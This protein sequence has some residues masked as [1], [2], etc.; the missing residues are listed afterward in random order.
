MIIE[1]R[2]FITAEVTRE[3]LLPP[4]LFGEAACVEL[5]T[6][7]GVTYVFVPDEV[8][9]PVEQPTEIAD[10]IQP[11]T[12]TADLR[13]VIEDASP[14]VALIRERVAAKIA[15]A[16]SIGDEIKLL[17]TAP[18]PEFELYN[19]YVEDCRAWGREQKALLGLV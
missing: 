5:A 10:S 19:A 1:Y 2:K 16:Y 17:R 9:L 4:E 8:D 11:V 3:L 13:R 15:D 7:A 18:S 6:I 12:L 14:H